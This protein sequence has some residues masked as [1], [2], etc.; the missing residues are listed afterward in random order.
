VNVARTFASFVALA[1][2]SLSLDA[3][4]FRYLTCDG[5]PVRWGGSIG[6]VQNL[7]SIPSG[8]A[9]AKA[10]A[11]TIGQWRGVGGMQDVVF[12]YGS[13]STSHCFVDLADGW[14][15]VAL[16]D[17]AAIDGALG[18][19]I[20]IRSCD[21]IQETNVLVANL[22][23]QSFDNPDEAFAAGACPFALTRTGRSTLLHE[24]GHAHGLSIT[25]AGGPDNHVLDFSI[26]RPSPP[27]PLGGGPSAMFAQPMPDDAA[28]GRFLYPS[29]VPET[30]LMASAQRLS[31]GSIR[32]TAPWKTIQRCRGEA[33]SFDFTTA[34][35][36][37][38]TVASDQRF[39]IATSPNAHTWTGITLGTWFGATVNAGKQVHPTVMTTIPCGTPKGLYWLYHQADAGNAVAESAENDNVIHNPLTIQVLDC[40]C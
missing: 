3:A 13:W 12:H 11:A 27:V 8:S 9:Q 29:T 40:G 17:A 37:T 24:F 20:V 25:S 10:Y 32:S 18:T 2:L 19:T 1:C 31:S 22:S 4:A 34:N 14:N 16:V 36:G 38:K 23:T 7:C 33:F 15:D 30:N 35:T 6:L 21:R 28:G 5:K 26:M 39:F